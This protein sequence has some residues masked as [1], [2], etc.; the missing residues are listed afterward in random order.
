MSRLSSRIYHCKLFKVNIKDYGQWCWWCGDENSKHLYIFKSELFPMNK[1]KNNMKDL[2][3]DFFASG[4]I[5]SAHKQFEKQ[6]VA[7]IIGRMLLPFSPFPD[8]L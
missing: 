8:V 1:N 3:I 6:K 2:Q 7:D 5:I 4:K